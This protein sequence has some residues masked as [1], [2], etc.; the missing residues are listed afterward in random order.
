MSLRLQARAELELRRRRATSTV[1]LDPFSTFQSRY[2]A[3]LLG[4]VHDCLTFTKSDGPTPYQDEILAELPTRHRIAVRGPHGIGKTALASWIALWATLTADDCK[5]PTTASAWRQLTKFLWPEVH[6]WSSR[7]RWDRIGREPFSR[8]EL[9]TLTLKRSSTC[10]AFAL[11]SNNADLIEG[12]HAS[13]LVYIFDEAKAIPVPT[14]DAAEGAFA[15]GDCYALAVSTPGQP[16]GRFYDIHRRAPGYSDWWTRHVTLSEAIAAGRVSRS[17]AEQRRRQ[18]GETSAVYQNRVLGEFAESSEDSVISLASVEAANRRWLEWRDAGSQVGVLTTVG[19]DVGRGGDRTILA[20]RFD[21]VL[22]EL[23]ASGKADTMDVVGRVVAALS[24]GG[25]AIVDVIGVGAG[26]VDRLR[27]QKKSVLA[28]NAAEKTLA[29]DRSG[30]LGFVNKRSAAWW[31]MRELLEGDSISLPPHD[32]LTGDLTAPTW[33][34]TSTG[35]IS[36]ESKD[37][38]RKRLHRSTDCADAVIQAFTGPALCNPRL[39][40]RVVTAQIPLR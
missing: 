21:D 13:R 32:E 22:A 33:T 16:T 39:G 18:W 38:I 14:W 36:V 24:R 17:W 10:E 28:F 4:F 20:L 27:E 34:H 11:A 19:V 29:R 23:R 3:D 30:E 6:K 37:T 40:G 12:A 26:V 8:A 5:V 31:A 7:L 25:V 15:T 2:R 35:K 1:I 9:L